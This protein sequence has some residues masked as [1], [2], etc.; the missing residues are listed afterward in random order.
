MRV[1]SI[2][3]LTAGV[4]A[5]SAYVSA[6]QPSVASPTVQATA[7]PAKPRPPS[8]FGPAQAWSPSANV[9]GR[10]VVSPPPSR[11]KVPALSQRPADPLQQQPTVVCGMTLIP[12]DPNVDAAIRHPIPPHG[13]TFRVRTL[14]PQLCTR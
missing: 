9:F 14:V 13:H 8:L 12:A 6:Q 4:V 1:A 7:P 11:P 3:A 10:R 5:G 2:V